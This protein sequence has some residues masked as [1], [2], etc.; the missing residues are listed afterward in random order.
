MLKETTD[1]VIALLTKKLKEAA[2]GSLT[3]TTEDSITTVT[4]W[5]VGQNQMTY[6][7]MIDKP[8]TP[9]DLLLKVENDEWDGWVQSGWD[10]NFGGTPDL[11]NPD[12]M[13]LD[14][15]IDHPPGELL[16]ALQKLSQQEDIY[17]RGSIGWC[18]ANRIPVNENL[19]D[20]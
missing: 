2:I 17:P 20:D 5:W 8:D 15:K 3:R 6:R 11:S 13:T 18:Q 7:Y 19:L 4:L 1:E 12:E 16:K 10:Q 14:Y 9:F